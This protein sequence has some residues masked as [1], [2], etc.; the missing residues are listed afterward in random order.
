MTN[1]PDFVSLLVIVCIGVAI[2]TGM[3]IWVWIDHRTVSKVYGHNLIG[4]SAWGWIIGVYFCFWLAIPW[5]VI[6]RRQQTLPGS[7][8]RGTI[9][10]SLGKR[11]GS[12]PR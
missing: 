1:G 5:Y 7:S 2:E 3:A 9:A 11:F 10:Y 8:G 4:R 6:R 12:K